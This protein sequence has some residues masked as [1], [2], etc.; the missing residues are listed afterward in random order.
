MDKLVMRLNRIMDGLVGCQLEF[1]QAS[2]VQLKDWKL[3]NKEFLEG[4]TESF[5]SFIEGVKPGQ[6]GFPVSI[7]G[8]FKGLVAISGWEQASGKNLF[9]LAELLAL[10]FQENIEGED[11]VQLL[12]ALEERIRLEQSKEG[13]NVVQFRSPKSQLEILESIDLTDLEFVDSEPTF[14]LDNKNVLIEAASGFPF[15]KIAIEMHHLSK[16]WA[17]LSL[18]D[19]SPQILDS[20]E[21]FEELGAITLFIRDLTV[22]TAEQQMKLAEYIALPTSV[23]RPCVVAGVTRPVA[24]LEKEGLL[25]TALLRVLT[26]CQIPKSGLWEDS[27]VDSQDVVHASLRFIV[28][29]TKEQV[30]SSKNLIPFHFQYFDPNSSRFH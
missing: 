22:L 2:Q 28:D 23:E 10:I 12:T 24:D 9:L 20:K 8:E 27:R 30:A 7:G 25:Q 19:V 29:Q 5:P 15:H 4:K 13:S 16:R 21:A 17:Q 26:V 14:E 6:F 18:E 3:S 11:K 1:R